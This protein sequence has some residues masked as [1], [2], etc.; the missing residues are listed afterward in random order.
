MALL[1]LLA[2]A[3]ALAS[4]GDP[5]RPWVALDPSR[6]GAVV[7]GAGGVTLA[8]LQAERARLAA[9]AAGAVVSGS[10]RTGADAN[11][12]ANDAG[13]SAPAGW[14][15]GLGAITLSTQWYVVPAGPTHDA[16]RRAARGYGLALDAL[17]EARRDALLDALDRIV[18]LE[19]LSAQEALAAARLTLAERT[20][21]AV[22]GQAAAG[23]AGPAALADAE[24]AR[25]QT[26]GDVLSVRHDVDAA[27]RAF[28]RAFAAEVDQLWRPAADP[29][30]ALTAAAAAIEAAAPPA[31]TPADLEAAIA[32]GARVGDATRALD[33][34][35]VA[36]DRAR[37]EAGV[38]VSLSVRVV[39]TG[40]AGRLTLG[41]G[42][43]TR[44]LQPSAELTY[45]PWNPAAAQ[46]TATLGANLSWSFG[47]GS[48]TS[49]AQAEIDEALAVERLQQAWS[50]AALELE[51]LARA[52]DQAGRA[53]D[54]ALERHAA[55]L[56]SLASVRVRTELGAVSPLD[57][58][59]AELDA[60]DAALALL[61]ADDQA[62]TANLRLELA[63]GRTPTFDPIAA[64]L[65]AAPTEVR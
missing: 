9:T 27:R 62:R 38:S 14:D 65:A 63:L 11:W 64:A 2:W 26:E 29:L 22:A 5:P 53:R 51:N 8:E 36:L 57:L 41:A 6:V 1:A 12:R 24:L 20:R 42:W 44:S 37:R 52:A 18:T 4:G 43:D 47:G 19:R 39:N 17:A 15:T 61:R 58:R 35:V 13:P 7:D 3:A 10:V 46:T 28:E 48:A 34:A 30:A 59:R 60:L 40:D 54:V 49:V 21:D 23:T 50:A 25:F 16:A 55:R 32:A 45:D 33:D 31:Y 56:A